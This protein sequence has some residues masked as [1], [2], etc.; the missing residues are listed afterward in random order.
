MLRLIVNA[1]VGAWLNWTSWSEWNECKS[2]SCGASKRGERWGVSGYKSQTRT[3][4]KFSRKTK[5]KALKP[6]DVEWKEITQG[7]NRITEYKNLQ[8]QTNFELIY[9]K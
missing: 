5:N 4:K 9:D 7:S 2:A 6:K 8:T 3:R 1:V